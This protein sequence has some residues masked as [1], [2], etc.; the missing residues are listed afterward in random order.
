[1]ICCCRC[2]ELLKLLRILRLKGVPSDSSLEQLVLHSLQQTLMEN[3]R[4]QNFFRVI[5]GLQVLLDGLGTL[6]HQGDEIDAGVR[7]ML[8]KERNV[9]APAT[10]RE[11]ASTDNVLVEFD[12]QL[13]S[14][15]V[16]REAMYPL[17]SLVLSVDA[18]FLE[19]HVLSLI[20]DSLNFHVFSDSFRN[21]VSLQSMRE[22]GGVQKFA[23][24]I[25]WAAFTI[26][27]VTPKKKPSTQV[28][29]GKSVRK[30]LSPQGRS[31]EQLSASISAQPSVSSSSQQSFQVTTPR[32]QGSITSGGVQSSEDV[33]EFIYEGINLRSW[34][35]RVADLCRI[36][37]SV[38]VPVGDAMSFAA[39]IQGGSD[40]AGNS[41]VY[42]EQATRFIIDVL[43]DVFQA[44]D[45]N[46][47]EVNSG[48]S[49]SDAF[50]SY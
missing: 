15:Q 43:I 39:G 30:N 22:H 17:S 35:W 4:S 46:L 19:W 37:C 45:G 23:Q 26:P 10:P 25:S 7:D 9:D 38:L 48:A 34:N 27:D 42:W 11:R 20:I 1:M 33:H 44:H 40:G 16:L 6:S 18:S 14:L 41:S 5:G 3:T 50:I 47:N 29:I 21:P 31:R 12:L 24:L 32:D 2:S 13:L 28:N 36:L 49:R 8:R